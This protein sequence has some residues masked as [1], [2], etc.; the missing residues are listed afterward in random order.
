MVRRFVQALMDRLRRLPGDKTGIAAVEF[1]VILPLMLVLYVGS[2]EVGQGFSI[3][4]KV[5]RVTSA[6]ND[7]VT[8]A[9][10]INNNDMRNILD[11]AASIITPYSA[12]NLKIVLTGVKVDGQGRPKAAWSDA[13]NTASR[14]VGS[15]VPVPEPLQ[16]PNT[17]LVVAEVDY[18]YKPIIGYVLTGTFNLHD[19]FF[20]R[21]RLTAEIERVQ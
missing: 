12:G 21:P 9:R 10:A 19:Q 14:A 6:L 2:V 1:V 8:Q 20:L 18:H 17:F 7:L 15:I 13:R 3:Q 16:I 11:A 5:T 4:R